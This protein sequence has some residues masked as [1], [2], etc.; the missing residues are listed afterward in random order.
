MRVWPKTL[1][2]AWTTTSLTFFLEKSRRDVTTLL[3]RLSAPAFG[4]WRTRRR[5]CRHFA[6]RSSP[7]KRVARR[8]TL[9]SIPSSPRRGHEELPP[10][11][12]CA[13]RALIDLG[14]HEGALRR[15]PGRGLPPG[16]DSGM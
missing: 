11:S 2:S 12:G 4:C 5:T 16:N 7:A 15:D 9:I 3:A 13:R 10:H 14:L 8:R 1:L 6:L